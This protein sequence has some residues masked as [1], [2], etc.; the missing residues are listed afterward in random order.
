[1]R[2]L[3]TLNK[4]YLYHRSIMPSAGN[5]LRFIAAGAAPQYSTAA[6]PATAGTT[7][8]VMKSDGTNWVSSASGTVGSIVI[9]VFTGNGTYTPTS[10]MIYALVEIVGGG[11]GGGGAAT[12]AGGQSAAG[13]G[14]GGGEY[15]RGVFSAATIGASQIV[16]IGAAGTAGAAGNNNGGGGGT[17]SLGALI[18]TVGGS[19]GSGSPSSAIYGLVGGTGGTGGSGGS[20]R[21]AGQVG[22]TSFGVTSLGISGCGG[23]SMLGLGGASR[24]DAVGLVGSGYGAGGSGGAC[25]SSTSELAGAAGTAGYILIVEYV[26]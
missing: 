21:V 3:L 18:T 10:G 26:A 8:N 17:S 6:Y 11:G 9:Q 19:G 22:G 24:H 1:M 15:A 14:G 2:Y 4:Q 12:G 13:S 16:T 20:F 23:S 25:D 5:I 7:G